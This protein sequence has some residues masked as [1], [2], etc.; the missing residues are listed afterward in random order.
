[1]LVCKVTEISCG[2]CVRKI[3]AAVD[4]IDDE[5]KVEVEQASGIVRVTTDLEAREIVRVIEDAGFDVEILP[6]GAA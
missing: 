3:I 6:E 1:M 4:N 2:G 5:A